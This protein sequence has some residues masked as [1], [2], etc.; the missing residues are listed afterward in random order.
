M[1]NIKEISRKSNH[2]ETGFACGPIGFEA[3]DAEITIEVDGQIVY[4]LGQWES[5]TGEYAFEA[6][7]ESIY[8]IIVKDYDLGSDEEKAAFDALDRIRA[9]AIKDD[10][11]FQPYYDQLTEMLHAEMEAHDIDWEDDDEEDD[12]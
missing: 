8:D 7:K 4:L 5:E 2:I 12:E 11:M 9:G 10:V 3:I 1:K 6:T